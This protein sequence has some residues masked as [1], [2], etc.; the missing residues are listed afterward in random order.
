MRACLRIAEQIGMPVIVSSAVETSI[1]LAASVAL[2]AALPELPYACG[3]RHHLTCST[4]DVVADP[5]EPVD[6]QPVPDAG[7]SLDEAAYAEVA[8]TAETDARWQARLS[9]VRE[10][11]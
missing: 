6:G 11:L 10:T 8:A 1:G 5:L 4:G 3:H 9:A 7:R 2:A